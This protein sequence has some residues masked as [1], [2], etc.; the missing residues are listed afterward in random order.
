MGQGREGMK[1]LLGQCHKEG[2]AEDSACLLRGTPG[3]L[4][5]DWS[6]CLWENSQAGAKTIGKEYTK[7]PQE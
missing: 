1:A 3:A 4:A 2:N 7:Q 5:E 6:A